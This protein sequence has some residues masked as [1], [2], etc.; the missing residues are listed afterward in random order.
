MKRKT[1]KLVQDETE[2]MEKAIAEKEKR[3]TAP[4]ENCI[5]AIFISTAQ[6]P[7]TWI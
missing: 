3:E 2:K 6:R 1:Y 4:L 7:K 5:D